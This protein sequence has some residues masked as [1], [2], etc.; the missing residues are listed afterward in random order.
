MAVITYVIV[1]PTGD[2]VTFFQNWCRETTSGDFLGLIAAATVGPSDTAEIFSNQN[3]LI[4]ARKNGVNKKVIT[5]GHQLISSIPSLVDSPFAIILALPQH[6]TEILQLS[7]PDYMLKIVATTKDIKGALNLTCAADHYSPLIFDHAIYKLMKGMS[8]IDSSRHSFPKLRVRSNKVADCSFHGAG[9]T[10]ANELVLFSL[11]F[12]ASKS[13]YIVPTDINN[14]YNAIADG[15]E[16]ILRATADYSEHSK[17]AVLY[18]PSISGVLYNT[19]SHFWNQI[20]RDIKRPAHKDFIKNGLIKNPDYSGYSSPGGTGPEDHPYND[21]MTATIVRERQRELKVTNYSIALLASHEAIPSIRL[22]N[23]VNLHAAQ[24]KDIEATQLR[25]DAKSRQQLQVK[26]KALSDQLADA[27]G[28]RIKHLVATKLNCLKICSDAPLEWV[29]LDKLPL[30]ISH[31]VSKIPMTPGNMLLQLASSGGELNVPFES[32]KDILVIRSFGSDDKIG[33]MLELGIEAFPIEKGTKVT[34]VDVTTVSEVISALNDFSG[35]AVVFDCHGN[36]D[37]PT[38][39]G[40]LKVGSEKLV[41]WD[42]HNQA[43]VP[44]IVMLS[45]CSTSAIGGSH[46]SVANGFVRSGALS[47]IGT[48]LPVNAAISAAFVSRIIFRIDSFLSILKKSGISIVTWRAFISS[49][50]RMSYATD[51][52]MYF[53]N[54]NPSFAKDDYVRIHIEVNL[55]I[56]SFDQEW[57]E[58]LVGE[59]AKKIECSSDEVIFMIRNETPLVET[60]L[61]CQIGR[62]ELVNIIL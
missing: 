58:Y 41:S 10:V 60:M 19:S 20:L 3:T 6:V 15:A 34:F 48:F 30:M 1:V 35:A 8:S 42:L 33:K 27:F 14:Y 5:I 18:A 50:L 36:H 16:S 32:L 24:L 44:P 22:P 37:G 12:K 47:V 49:F 31:E 29:F 13:T 21:P 43:R 59:V 4:E 46:A 55:R 62:P 45:A 51:V 39:S 38:G 61:Y 9:C 57:Y 40:W 56:N 52:L 2:D 25:S 17:E 26:F 7:F 23:S 53:L 28:A 54:N 11:G